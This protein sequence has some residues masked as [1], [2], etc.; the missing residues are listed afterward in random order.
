M[1]KAPDCPPALSGFSFFICAILKSV[2]QTTFP[3]GALKSEA[4]TIQRVEIFAQVIPDFA[5]NYIDGKKDGIK[6][7]LVSNPETIIKTVPML[8]FHLA[9]QRHG[10]PVAAV[11]RVFRMVEVTPLTEP[12][13]PVCGAIDFQGRIVSV[14]DV[15]LLFGLPSREAE[16][17]DQLILMNGSSGPAAL[18]VDHGVQ[19]MAVQQSQITH[20]KDLPLQM[21]SAAGMVRDAEGMIVLHDA[22]RLLTCLSPWPGN[23]KKLPPD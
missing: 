22:G 23:D 16:L 2:V 21:Q 11:E 20:V 8:V 12:H 13:P 18:W 5:D 10:L 7:A 19:I 6:D 4:W 17:E 9:G 15:R 3:R 14:I 1:S